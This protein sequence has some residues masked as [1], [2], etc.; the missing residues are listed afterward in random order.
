MPPKKNS[1]RRQ[2]RGP[3]LREIRRNKTIPQD[4]ADKFTD[5]VELIATLQKAGQLP[6]YM[7][8]TGDMDPE[9]LTVDDKKK[10]GALFVPIDYM[11]G[12]KN[13]KD[14]HP[15]YDKKYN[16]GQ[17]AKS[18]QDHGVMQDHARKHMDQ[19]ME[20]G[21]FV[22]VEL[23]GERQ[24][25]NKSAKPE[26]KN[27]YVIHGSVC[28]TVPKKWWTF[29][30]LEVVSE[31]VLIEGFVVADKSTN[32]TSLGRLK[33]KRQ[34]FYNDDT[35]LQKGL[36]TE[37]PSVEKGCYTDKGLQL[38]GGDGMGYFNAA[39]KVLEDGI[40]EQ[41]TLAEI[42]DLT[43]VVKSTAE[44]VAFQ[45][46]HLFDGEKMM[47]FFQTE[48]SASNYHYVDGPVN[49]AERA[50][51]DVE[52]QMKFDGETGIIKKDDDGVVHLMVKF[53]VDVYE[54]IGDATDAEY[55]FGWT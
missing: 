18:I 46:A 40:D 39:I 3:N 44:T 54:I 42:D 45:K 22:T 23:M 53:Q 47:N 16:K 8:S 27:M 37:A 11:T 1:G 35:S 13:G 25:F 31:K 5:I 30:G 9:G 24:P 52:F 33:L 17:D 21:D 50:E 20:N 12:E 6:F 19:Y 26:W 55:R 4:H 28:A 38:C 51:E 7:L 15:L 34:N 29:E 48:G 41:I 10:H 43:I 32:G 2:T 49:I 14:N 36:H